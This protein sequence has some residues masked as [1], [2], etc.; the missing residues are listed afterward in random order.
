MALAAFHKTSRICGAECMSQSN[1]DYLDV[2][3]KS[4][5]RSPL[6]QNPGNSTLSLVGS[7]VPCQFNAYKALESFGHL[8]MQ[9]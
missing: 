5:P 6:E 7:Q 3:I 4:P 9:R 2:K 1:P 8:L